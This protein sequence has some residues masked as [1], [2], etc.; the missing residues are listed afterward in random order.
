MSL[1]KVFAQFDRAARRLPHLH[2]DGL[3]PSEQLAQ[4]VAVADIADP[5]DLGYLGVG[6][7]EALLDTYGDEIADEFEAALRTHRPFAVAYG[8][9]AIQSDELSERFA[10][11]I[12][13]DDEADSEDEDPDGLIRSVR[14]IDTAT[15]LAVD[16]SWLRRRRRRGLY[17]GWVHDHIVREGAHLISPVAVVSDEPGEPGELL[18][19]VAVAMTD[20]VRRAALMSVLRT[21]FEGLPDALSEADQENSRAAMEGLESLSQWITDRM[22]NR[23]RRP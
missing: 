11:L 10:P 16:A 9:A 20:G 18:C 12:P 1:D 15:L 8:W 19:L 3:S 17:P 6:P 7:I 14:E 13:P 2:L 4:I 21:V 5:D 22:P 23:L